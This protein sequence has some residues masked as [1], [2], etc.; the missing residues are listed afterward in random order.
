[1]LTWRDILRYINL[2]LY[3]NWRY[4]ETSLT[5]NVNISVQDTNDVRNDLE[6]EEE[7]KE[8]GKLSDEAK[9]IS[10]S[11][12]SED[13]NQNIQSILNVDYD[14]GLA[15]RYLQMLGERNESVWNHLNEIVNYVVRNR[16][17][18]SMRYFEEVS[19]DLR[20]KKY[21][22][23]PD[24]FEDKRELPK[25]LEESNKLLK[26]Y[27]MVQCLHDSEDPFAEGQIVDIDILTNFGLLSEA[28]V[29]IPKTEIFN[30]YMNMRLLAKISP[31]K[32]II[33]WGKILGTL[34]DY[35]I[36]ESEPSEKGWEERKARYAE[37]TEFPDAIDY[38][39]EE[40]GESTPM[41]K[42]DENLPEDNPLLIDNPYDRISNVKNP[43]L[44]NFS[45]PPLP[46]A[47]FTEERFPPNEPPGEGVNR[48]VYYVCNDPT[49]EWIELPDVTPQQI[50]RARNIRK[51]FTGILDTEILTFPSYPWKERHLLRAQIA[52]IS[53]STHVSPAG[54]YTNGS[55]EETIPMEEGEL[56]IE[57]EEYNP[58][59]LRELVSDDLEYWVHHKQFILSHGTT[60]AW[61][62]SIEEPSEGLEEQPRRLELPPDILRSLSEDV[63]EEGGP[64]WTARP[65]AKVMDE[66]SGV[67]LRSNVWPGAVTVTKDRLFLNCYMGWGY[68]AS[69]PTFK[70]FLPGSVQKEYPIG[71]EI[72]EMTDPTVEMEEARWQQLHPVIIPYMGG[73]EMVSEEAP[74][75]DEDFD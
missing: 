33:F 13:K 26:F 28:G 8:E 50:V 60:S 16:R 9:K 57:N 12:W 22:R 65:T 6:G 67:V 41:K 62:P 46:T 31:I 56:F 69:P 68:K 19:R 27:R 25:N 11:G 61:Q 3:C 5:S 20:A 39:E 2:I 35:Y 10:L 73:E 66:N 43:K 4:C 44:R 18:D 23:Q 64:V 38:V 7:E 71:P 40:G 15:K 14:L 21:V 53:A 29:G 55:E 51:I 45:I 63:S 75:D 1:M 72:M 17:P 24:T 34:R 47:E 70:P 48:Y 59:A 74:M 37:K 42:E 52:R 36:V 54:F 49:G 58:F 32:K 30:L